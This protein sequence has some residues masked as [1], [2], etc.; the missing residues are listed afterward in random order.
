MIITQQGELKMKLSQKE[1]YAVL[2][3]LNL[4]SNTNE[5]RLSNLELQKLQLKIEEYVNNH[6]KETA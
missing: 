4:I 2:K 1:L 3:G 5:T 6:F